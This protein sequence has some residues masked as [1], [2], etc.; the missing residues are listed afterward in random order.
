MEM[1]ACALLSRCA[2]PVKEPDLAKPYAMRGTLEV[3]STPFRPPKCRRRPFAANG[4]LQDEV[5]E[6]ENDRLGREIAIQE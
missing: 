1:A 6:V 2:A 5:N 3:A 4:S